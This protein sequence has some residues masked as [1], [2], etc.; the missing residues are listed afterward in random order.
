MDF[1]GSAYPPEV[2]SE[3][4]PPKEFISLQKKTQTQIGA[5]FSA[6][7]LQGCIYINITWA[8]LSGLSWENTLFARCKQTPPKT[9][10]H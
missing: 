3:R 5:Y 8:K 7:K 2:F 4:S 6:G 1:Q 10:L 9:Y